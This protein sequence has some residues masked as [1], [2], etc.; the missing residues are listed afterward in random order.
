MSSDNL[1]ERL[2]ASL[3]TQIDESVRSEL[4]GSASELLREGSYG[5]A[6]RKEEPKDRSIDKHL[7]DAKY[8]LSKGSPVELIF[9]VV[10]TVGAFAS[11]LTLPA[12]SIGGLAMFLYQYRRRS[13]DVDE[14]DAVILQVLKEN[15]SIGLSALEVREALP[16]EDSSKPEAHEVEKRLSKLGRVRLRSGETAEFA[17]SEDGKW[18]AVNL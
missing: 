2:S 15:L 10:L 1:L 9:E 5:A 13:A 11:V 3:S 12:A 8:R 4:V 16:L 17:K 6:D 7:G 14:M 18:W